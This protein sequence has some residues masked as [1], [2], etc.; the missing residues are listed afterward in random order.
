[1]CE[2]RNMQ[3]FSDSLEKELGIEDVMIKIYPKYY[4]DEDP[5]AFH[6]AI[7][8]VP[9]PTWDF[10]GRPWTIKSFSEKLESSPNGQVCVVRGL[11]G[12]GKTELVRKL[13]K[14]NHLEQGV[15]CVELS[16]SDLESLL[17][18]LKIFFKELGGNWKG[19][20][21]SDEARTAISWVIPKIRKTMD[22]ER[23]WLLI[24]ED[25][26]IETLDP[27]EEV[28][29][30]FNQLN[31]I[32]FL[33]TSSSIQPFSSYWSIPVD[34]FEQKE[35]VELVTLH[36]E[37]ERI[38]DI[39]LLC[40]SMWCFPLVL[41]QAICFILNR[42]RNSFPEFSI[43]DLCLDFDSK[44]EVVFNYEYG[45]LTDNCHRT[46]I[47][48]YSYFFENPRK[49]YKD[50]TKLLEKLC[51]E[52]NSAIGYAVVEKLSCHRTAPLLIRLLENYFFLQKSNSI[53]FLNKTIHKIVKCRTASRK[54]KDEKCHHNKL[55]EQNPSRKSDF[56]PLSNISIFLEDR[57][58]VSELLSM[59]LIGPLTKTLW[60]C[61]AC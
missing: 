49:E 4:T 44:P 40:K 42:R 15:E 14:M 33:A 19:P 5:S 59:K 17:S 48:M 18:S 32:K 11:A 57:I 12:I 21:M 41:K 38:D 20:E 1:M 43:K 50:A 22:D 23:S 29:L 52:A 25:V 37:K 58:H 31:S 56:A 46:P 45:K 28:I 26:T 13:A 9:S 10:I 55:Q 60:V 36:L 24:L 53:I 34:V 47:T 16:C 39:S 2:I 51:N 8:S 30:H 3:L 6:S 27:L 54:H 61:S 7:F 35:A